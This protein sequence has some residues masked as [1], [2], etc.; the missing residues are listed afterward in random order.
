MSRSNT[1]LMIEVHD[2]DKRFAPSAVNETVPFSDFSFTV[3]RGVNPLSAAPQNPT[4]KKDRLSHSLEL[5]KFL[6]NDI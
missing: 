1:Q 3:R 2:I 6:T 5:D 4:E